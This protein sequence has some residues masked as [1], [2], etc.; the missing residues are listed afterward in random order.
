M[1]HCESQSLFT[2]DKEAVSLALL[3][4]LSPDRGLLEISHLLLCSREICSVERSSPGFSPACVLSVALP[5]PQK[6]GLVSF[7]TQSPRPWEPKLGWLGG[8]GQHD[9]PLSYGLFW[10]PAWASPGTVISV[11]DS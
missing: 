3:T 1:G 5:V 4:Q 11:T 10:E 2:Q 8:Q 6:A 7:T 9:T